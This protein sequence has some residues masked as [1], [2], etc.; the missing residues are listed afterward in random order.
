MAKRIIIILNKKPTGGG[1]GGGGREGEGIK[2]KKFCD[3]GY[4]KVQNYTHYK[5]ISLCGMPIINYRQ[6]MFGT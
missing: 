6:Y 1:G 3:T 2:D 5:S 4:A